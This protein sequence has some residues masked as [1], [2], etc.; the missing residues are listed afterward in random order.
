MNSAR[1]FFPVFVALASMLSWVRLLRTGGK[2]HH[3]ALALVESSTL[4]VLLLNW[5]HSGQLPARMMVRSE[6]GKSNG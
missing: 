6:R 1:Q 3:L 5:S 4:L 2:M